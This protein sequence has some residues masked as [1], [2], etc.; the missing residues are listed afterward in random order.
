VRI[1]LRPDGPLDADQTLARYR[2]WGEDPANRLVGDAFYRVVPVDRRPHG[3]ELRWSGAVDDPCL[4]ITIPGTRSTQ[5]AEAVTA[6]VSRL[7]FLDADLPGFYRMAKSDRILRT[8]ILP[9]YGMRPTLAP[10]PFEMLVGAITAQQV[11]L[12]FAFATRSRLVRRFGRPVD[13]LGQTVYAFPEPAVLARAKVRELRAMQFST[14]KAEY[15]IGLARLVTSGELDFDRLAVL[16]NEEI[17]TALTTVRGLGLWT[18][19]WFLARA[20]GRGDVCPAGDLAVR[21][22]FEHF[23]GRGRPLS[24][25]AIRHRA[26]QWGPHQNLAVHYL[27]AGMRR[28]RTET[29]GGT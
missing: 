23:Y 3:Y 29:G 11:N 7:L 12:T 8:L 5:V 17:V 24:D 18:A 14:R 21:K 28:S 4:T 9:L 26:R 15:L 19:E 27:L 6:Q 1:Q 10:T 25:R 2:I 20:L 13:V 16:S 22:A